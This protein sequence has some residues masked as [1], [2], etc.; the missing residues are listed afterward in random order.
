VYAGRIELQD[1][2]PKFPLPDLSAEY[3]YGQKWGYVE[4]AGIVRR[5]EWED[6]GTDQFNLSG[7]ATGWG[8]NLS[9]NLKFGKNDVVRLQGMYGEGVENYMNDAPA[10]VGIENQ[11]GN[12]SAPVKGVALPVTGVVAFLDHTWNEKFTT[13]IGYSMVD[14]D[15]SNASAPDAFKRGQYA[16]G[17]VLYSPVP[18]VTTGVELQWGNREN[19]SNDFKADIF[20]VQFSF[21]YAFSKTY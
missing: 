20:K 10:D 16:L 1:V 18:G 7:N 19:F 17:N 13:A 8:L 5:I 3:R 14:I 2:K 12:P 21:K 11:S 15:N 9:S 6:Q 4:L